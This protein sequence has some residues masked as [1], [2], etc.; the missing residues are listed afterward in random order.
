VY[1]Y[2]T[3]KTR[4]PPK[5]VSTNPFL[6]NSGFDSLKLELT[7]D[8]KSQKNLVLT[9]MHVFELVKIIK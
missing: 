6:I 8:F 5:V 1:V 9:E 7:A 3:V 4:N 2:V